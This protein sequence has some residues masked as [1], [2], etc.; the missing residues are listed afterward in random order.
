MEFL[1]VISRAIKAHVLLWQGKIA[2]DQIYDASQVTLLS[3]RM[4]VQHSSYLKEKKK[5][6]YQEPLIKSADFIRDV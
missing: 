5:K 4:E 2:S 6:E 3:H 1:H